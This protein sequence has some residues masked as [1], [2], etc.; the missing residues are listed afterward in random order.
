MSTSQLSIRLTLALV[1]LGLR[2]PRHVIWSVV[3]VVVLLGALMV[4]I[5]VDTDPENM[6]PGDHPVRE[7]NRE[8]RAEFGGDQL[9]VAGLVSDQGWG[10]AA[11][12]RVG[13]LH[14]QLQGDPRIDGD[15]I[16]SVASIDGV[17]TAADMVEVQELADAHPVLGGLVLTPDGTTLAVFVPIIDKDDAAETAEDIE[18][19]IEDDPAFAGAEIALAGLRWP[20]TRS[21]PRCSCRWVCSH[22]SPVRSS[23]S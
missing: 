6:L 3:G 2:R 14:R 12:E 16:A 22:P 1:R 19:L 5:Q 7:L 8:I 23:S 11:I 4:R 17:G 20:R 21:V 18:R 10:I 9:V 15:R 13:A